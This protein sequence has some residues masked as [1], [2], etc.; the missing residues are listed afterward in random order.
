[1]SLHYDYH[2]RWK[3]F[4]G[5]RDT[6]WVRIAPL[7]IVIGANNSGKSSLLA[8]LIL[9]Q[10]T[11]QSRDPNTP[12]VTR[13][14]TTD[15]GFYRDYSH[16]HD[17]GNDIEFGFKF[18]THART[19]GERLKPIATYPPGAFKS[20]FSHVVSGKDLTLQRYDLFDI[21][22]RKMLS[23]EQSKSG[24]KV[25]AGALGEMSNDEQKAIA[26]SRPVNF[27]FSSSSVLYRLQKLDERNNTDTFDFEET[28]EAFR[29]YLAIS[30]YA[31]EEIR[32]QLYNFYYIGPNREQPKRAYDYF[33]NE[34]SG[35]GKEGE[36][37]AEMLK[38]GT[39]ELR[40]KVNKWVRKLGIGRAIEIDDLSGD[41]FSI[42]LRSLNGKD[43]NNIAD[44]GFGISQIL[45]IVVQLMAAREESL[46][47]VKQP[48]LHL[49]PKL[50]RNIADIFVDRATSDRR[51][52]IE[53]H[54]EHILLRIRTLV[55]EGKIS[56]NDIALYFVE[57]HGA[58][59]SATKIEISELGHIQPN[60]W[61]RDFF[62][63]KFNG[64]M[65]LATAQREAKRKA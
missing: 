40:G 59:S 27:L 65:E 20:T 56:P 16:R 28:S 32:R 52:A 45:P 34:P 35:V 7:T 53:T 24:Y 54:S 4:R 64:A 5:F 39:E 9:M 22:D 2:V 51:V 11:I 19:K 13:G 21:F 63:E 26:S 12:L 43:R 50:Q 60:E 15:V 37:F 18:H 42:Y 38:G 29:K 44:L 17:V 14:D 25:D 57:R 61:P 31:F 58:T 6:K 30:S 36:Y 46:T 41:L 48:E 55:A 49:N 23:I 8:P 33:G 1:M 47:I 62:S 3:N 10:Q